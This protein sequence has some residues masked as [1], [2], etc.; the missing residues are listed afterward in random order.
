M[1][2]GRVSSAQRA[3]FDAER[4]RRR[5]T[6]SELLR[7]IIDDLVNLRGETS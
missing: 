2:S 5:K 4:R 7:E 1:I 6:A 3:R